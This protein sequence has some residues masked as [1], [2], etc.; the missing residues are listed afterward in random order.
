M[1]QFKFS[2]ALAVALVALAFSSCTKTDDNYREVT[3]TLNATPIEYDYSQGTLLLKDVWK[4]IYDTNAK[5]VSQNI[6]FS[7]TA[8]PEYFAWNGFAPSRSADKK[9]YSTGNWLEHQWSA[10]TEGGLSG[11][12][13][14]YLVAY[15][16]SMEKENVAIADASCIIKYGNDAKPISFT[17]QSMFI[18]N[19][20]YAFYSMTNGSAYSKKFAKGDY[21]VLKV[22]GIKSDGSRVGPINAYLADYRSENNAEWVMLKEWTSVNLEALGTVDYIYFQMASSDTGQWGMNNPGY[23]CIDR[24]KI[25]L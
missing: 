15:W 2:S 23:C 17:P 10:I 14:P 12:G 16:N 24:L 7:H 25:K 11:K 19:N 6:W 18:T 5:L 22:Y 1:K 13:T 8:I 9:D 20:T 4:S 3:L 21:F